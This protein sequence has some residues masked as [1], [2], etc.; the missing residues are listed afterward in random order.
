MRSLRVLLVLVLTSCAATKPAAPPAG[1]EPHV[2]D[3]W[4]AWRADALG[5]S[6]DEARARDAKLPDGTDGTAPPEGT[7]DANTQVEAAVL[8]SQECAR[9][10]GENGVPPPVAEGQVQ[11]REWGGMGP[12][13]G[14][15]MGGDKM[16]AGIYETI[17]QGKGTM[18]GW[19]DALSREQIWA[20]VAHIE[21]F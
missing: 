18:A 1:A 8:W 13:M 15:L 14:F 5:I 3:D 10:H 19:G 17:A 16:R 20:L 4:F 9:C 2:G 6:V 7:L 21:S 11:P 12:A